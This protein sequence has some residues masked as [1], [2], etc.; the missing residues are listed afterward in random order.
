MSLPAPCRLDG[1]DVADHVRDGHVRRCQL[2]DVTVRP[3][4]PGDG[5][6]VALLLHQ[7]PALAANRVVGI[8]ANLAPGDVRH[9][10]VQQRGQQADDARL[11]LPA[12][13]QQNEVVPRQQRVHDLRDNGFLKTDDARKQRLFALQLTNQVLTNFVFY[14]A[15]CDPVLGE[16]TG[17]EGAERLRKFLHNKK[18]GNLIGRL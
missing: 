10:F 17:S 13:P 1:I 5:R 15:V 2:L 11:G 7:R 9:R 14:G 4:Q 18:A 6:V 12:Q 3:R 16:A 8:V